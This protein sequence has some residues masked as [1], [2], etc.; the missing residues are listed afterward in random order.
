MGSNYEDM[1]SVDNE[2][3]V[4]AAYWDKSIRLVTIDENG[5]EIDCY[6]RVVEDLRDKEK[7]ILE[8]FKKEQRKNRL[9][10]FAYNVQPKMF[11]ANIVLTVCALIIYIICVVYGRT[12][13]SRSSDTFIGFVLQYNIK[14]VCKYAIPIMLIL[15]FVSLIFYLMGRDSDKVRWLL[16]IMKL[17]PLSEVKFISDNK[18]NYIK[19]DLYNL[20]LRKHKVKYTRHSK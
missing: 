13:I 16:G 10:H 17:R 5:M 20:Q 1:S 12:D 7:K 4:P 11:V 15:S 9:I 14:N 18:I 2:G 6:D 8:S 3:V 19:S